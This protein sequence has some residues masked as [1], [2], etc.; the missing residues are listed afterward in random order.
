P[1]VEAATEQELP[2]DVVRPSEPLTD[3]TDVKIPPKDLL[4]GLEDDL[5]A[6]REL[7]KITERG[8]QALQKL[9]NLDKQ[10]RDGLMGTPGKGQ[11]GPGSGGGKGRGIGAGEG[12]GEGDRGKINQRTKRKLRW[13]ITFN[14]SS[15]Q[16]Y[17]RQ[18]HV[19]GAILAFR[20]PDGDVRVV[21]DLI[22]RPVKMEVEDLQALNRI[23]WID[24]KREAVEQLVRA[25]GL[26]FTP[27]QIVALFPY[28]FE[29][30][31]LKKELAFRN[32]QEEQIHETRFLVVVR[33]STYE[34]YV[35][36]QRLN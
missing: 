10:L 34:I 35:T 20:H 12:D 36:Q 29:Q 3:I 22:R 31:L 33:G 30:Q 18:L 17:L 27:N 11:G 32:K 4:Q 23:F 5:E 26:D 8:T 16:D 25:L 15:G 28:D 7:A 21:K 13:T 19:L 1:R 6:Q 2:P 24:D 14:T 9:A